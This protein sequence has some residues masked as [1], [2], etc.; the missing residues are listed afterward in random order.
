M[1]RFS[2]FRIDENIN[3]IW[4]SQQQQYGNPRSN[5]I[6]LRGLEVRGRFASL[7]RRIMRNVFEDLPKIR[8]RQVSTL[9]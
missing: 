3:S 8:S 2:R 6:T 4:L 1:L 5:F 7:C 9:H